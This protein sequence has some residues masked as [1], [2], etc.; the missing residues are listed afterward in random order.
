MGR[1]ATI[2]RH[3][4]AVIFGLTIVGAGAGAIAGLSLETA[5]R[6]D[7]R[8]EPNQR[9]E[10]YP[11]WDLPAWAQAA[12][13]NNGLGKQYELQGT[14]VDLN[15]DDRPELLLSMGEPMPGVFI[16][17]RPLK[18]ASFDGTSW[19]VTPTELACQPR[20]LGTFRS[21]GY[22]DLM[23][24]LDDTIHVLRWNGETYATADT[25]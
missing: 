16:P 2:F 12:I 11:A 14:V 21:D 23:C 13:R 3:L 8:A 5:D 22:W 10:L 17:H 7:V 6:F 4:S 18:I 15:G 9:L 19:H 24:A 1:R 25:A 20:R